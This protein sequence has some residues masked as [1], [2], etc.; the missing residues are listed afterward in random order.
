MIGVLLPALF[1]YRGSSALLSRTEYVDDTAAVIIGHLIETAATLGTRQVI[2][3]GLRPEV[4]AT[5]NSMRL[6][7]RIPESNF[8]ANLDDAK[9]VAKPMPARFA[10]VSA[11]QLVSFRRPYPHRNLILPTFNLTGRGIG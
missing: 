5:L 2:V 9:L 7:D 1:A 8:V 11:E 4:A 6:L 3:V 10:P